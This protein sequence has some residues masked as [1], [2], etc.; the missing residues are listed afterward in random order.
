MEMFPAILRL[1]RKLFL[2]LL[3]CF[4]CMALSG[5][6]A[7][8]QGCTYI[9]DGGENLS[10]RIT[11]EDTGKEVEN[12]AVVPAGTRLRFDAVAEAYGRCVCER[13]GTVYERTVNHINM[14]A[15]ISADGSESVDVYSPVWGV[16]RGGGTA[17][18]HV[19]DT[20]AP[21]STGPHT[22]TY[23][24]RGV[25]A[26]H[27]QALINTTPCGIQPDRTETKT[28]KIEVN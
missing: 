15:D 19:L 6:E 26:F 10:M 5:V 21:N 18:W 4:A 28:I 17:F 22:Q 2:M 27:S 16:Y 1:R 12:G 8:A 14:W 9:P 13:A 24:D 23:T 20:A 25:Y 3:S 7:R 11:N